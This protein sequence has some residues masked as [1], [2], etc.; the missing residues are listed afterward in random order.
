MDE[1]KEIT[2]HLEY[3]FIRKIIEGL[4]DRSISLPAAKQ[5]AIEFTDMQPFTTVEDAKTKMNQFVS[6]NA[7]FKRLQEYTDAYHNEKKL[8]VVIEKMRGFMQNN[9]IDQALEVASTHS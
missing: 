5:F 8:G 9:Q 2:D 3:L 1:L 6:K 4:R 7:T